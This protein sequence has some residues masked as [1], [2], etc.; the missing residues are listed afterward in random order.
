MYE[1]LIKMI[2]PK[3]KFKFPYSFDDYCNNLYFEDYHCHKAFSNV[4]TADSGEL[5]S[6]YVD[7]IKELNAKCLFSGEHGS[8]GNQFEIYTIAEKEKLKYRHSTE[9]YWVKNRHEKDKTNCHMV[10]VAKNKQGREDINYVLSMANIDGYYYRPRI[11]LNLL[12]DI[13]KDNVIVTSAC[14]AGWGYKDADDIWIK[15]HNYF[16]NNF[17][18]ELQ[19]N[20]TPK[21]IELNKYILELSE[22]YNIQIIAGLDSHYISDSG[23]IKREQILKYKKVSYPEEEGWYM[24]YPDVHTLIHRFKEQGVLNEEQILTS[25]MNTNVFVEECEEIVLDKS[26]KIPNIYKG[27]SY[28]ERVKIYHKILNENYAKESLKS[29]AKADGIRYEANEVTESGVVDYFLDNY[30]LVDLAVN[31]Y[32]GI[33][34][35]TS[36]GSAASFVT[37]RLL[38]FTTVDRFNSDIPIYPERFLTKERVMAGQMPDIDLNVAT[39]EPFEKAGKELFGENGCYPLMAVGVLKEKSAWALYAGANGVSSQ[40]SLKIS[41]YL[42]EYNKALKYAEEDEKEFIQAEDFIPD[43]YIELYNKSKEYQSITI[44]LTKHACGYILLDGDIRREIGLIS[45]ISETTGERTLV[46]CVEGKYLD[47][48][49]YV[50]DDF[51]IVDSVHLTYK[52]FKSIGMDVPSFEE[53]KTMIANDKKTWEIYEKGITCCVNQCEQ[54]KTIYKVMKYKPKSLAELSAFIAAIRPGFASSLK[55]FLGRESY[56]TGEKLIDELLKDTSHFMLYQES[57]MKVLSFLDMKM[58]DTYGVIKAISKKKY[59]DHPEKLAELKEGLLE[60][61]KTKISNINNFETVWKIIE[62][63]AFYAFNSPHAYSMGG[64]SAYQAWF[65]ANYTMIFYEVAINHYQEKEKKN[66]IDALIKECIKFYGLKLGGYKFGKDNRKVT[67]DNEEMTIYP[68][69]SSVKNFGEKVVT[70]LYEIGKRKYDNFIEILKVIS[71]TSINSSRVEDLIK[72][73]YFSEF[74]DV[75]KLLTIKKYYE[76]IYNAKVLKKDKIKE[77]SLNESIIAKYG[78]ETASQYNQLDNVKI[79]NELIY[80]IEY[81]PLSIKEK[82]DIEKDILGII[83]TKDSSISKRIYYV[84]ELEVLKSIVNVK[85]YEIYSGI[86]REVKM[87]T[88]AYNRKPFNE[89]DVLHISVLEKKNKK[90]PTG[91]IDDKTGKKIYMDVPDKFEF[92]LSKYFIKQNIEENNNETL[93]YR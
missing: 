75:N 73:G 28:D 56:S 65:K 39:Q 10:I 35:T 78:H 91:E 6:A 67:I 82:L 23:N 52:L 8:Q 74:G 48:F 25:I 26:F 13:P 57:I 77:N 32:G 2:I 68:N 19:A 93:L 89:K 43:E 27:K 31:K 22:K 9:A 90:E 21:Q 49:G 55:T 33:L 11:D 92:W 53:L 44:N 38:G 40:D 1:T 37:N 61:W 81:K 50:K 83:T 15:I 51:L 24:D 17:F 16:G 62:D 64:D 70:E 30:K 12:F 69:L 60:A 4:Y 66:K 7:R 71:E 84:S 80:N 5:V 85:L 63:S 59:K 58:N 88:N 34:T 20:N 41:K 87:W 46:A 79:L 3:L 45:A 54:P 86:T 29:K 76:L 42:D 36:R 14:I 18:F 72:I 47:D